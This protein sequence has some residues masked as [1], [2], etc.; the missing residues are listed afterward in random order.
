MDTTAGAALAGAHL[1]LRYWMTI[2]AFMY[3]FAGLTFLFGQNFLARRMNNIS[4]LLFKT[5]PLM[6]ESSEKFWLVLTTS[7][8]LMLV[9]CCAFVAVDPEKYLAITVVVL[10]SKLCSTLLYFFFFARDKYF[11]YLVGAL[12]DG[13]LFLATLSLFLWAAM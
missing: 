7:M 3:F 8:M 2:S 9:I 1:Y 5:R 11:A 12:T 6:P 13:P 4:G 10:A